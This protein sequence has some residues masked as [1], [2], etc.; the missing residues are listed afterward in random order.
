VGHRV[1]SLLLFLGPVSL[2]LRTFELDCLQLLGVG[3]VRL[4]EIQ[5]YSTL[6]SCRLFTLSESLIHNV[7]SCLNIFWASSDALKFGTAT[8][9]HL[10]K[11]KKSETSPDKLQW[12]WAKRHFFRWGR[13]VMASS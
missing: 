7:R 1:D 13:P 8:D 10:S 4:P 9:C 3:W 11:A 6:D 2:R 5:Q 12:K